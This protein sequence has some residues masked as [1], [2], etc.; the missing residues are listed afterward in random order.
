MLEMML[1]MQFQQ[2]KKLGS[3][4]ITLN[5][6]PAYEMAYSGSKDG[7]SFRIRQILLAAGG[8]TYV[9]TCGAAAEHYEGAAKDFDKILKS[10][11]IMK[12][13]PAKGAKGAK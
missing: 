5:Q 2:F 10:F 8:K 7:L 3:G 6:L 11:K 13:Q 4:R 1:P 12:P 9:I